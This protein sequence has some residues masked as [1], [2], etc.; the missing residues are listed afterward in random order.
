MGA[1]AKIV[2]RER[3]FVTAYEHKEILIMD[4]RQ[5]E[6]FNKLQESIDR[7]YRLML[8]IGVGV[9]AGCFLF[10]VV[11]ASLKAAAWTAIAGMLCVEIETIYENKRRAKRLSESRIPTE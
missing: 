5:K 10:A 9:L 7:N 11:G 8:A 1:T 6:R 4:E 3:N 2:A